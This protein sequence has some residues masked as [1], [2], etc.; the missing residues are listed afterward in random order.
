VA[1]S[2]AG[3]FSLG[4]ESLTAWHACDPDGQIATLK[5]R[6]PQGTLLERKGCGSVGWD[7]GAG[8]AASARPRDGTA[9]P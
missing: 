7:R 9:L 1:A 6:G 2:D 5:I 8:P 3:Q 4:G